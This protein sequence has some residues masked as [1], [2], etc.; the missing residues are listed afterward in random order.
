MTAVGLLLSGCAAAG[1]TAGAS[2]V[3]TASTPPAVTV[4]APTTVPRSTK[5]PTATKA[6]TKP[7]TKSATTTNA[8]SSAPLTLITEPDQGMASID[9][10][11]AS[12]R[13]T[14]DMTMYELVD[15]TAESILAADAARGVTVRVVL[16]R[17]REEAANTPAY[18]YLTS[19][20]VHVRWAPPSFEATHEK[21]VVIDAGRPGARALIMTLNLT[22]EY[23]SDTRDFAVIDTDPSDVAAIETVFAADYAGQPV[24]EPSGAD[25]VWSP[26][27]KATL[28]SLIDSA[29]T[30][31][32]VEN[33]EMSSTAIIDALTA[34]AGRGVNVEVT[35]TADSEWDQ[36]FAELT[37]AGA[38]VHLYAD[39]STVL[40]IHAKAIVADGRRAFVGSENFSDA[41]LDENRE[42]GILTQSPAIVSPLT[43]V[44]AAD[45][46]GAAQTTSPSAPV[47]V[48]ASP[49]PQSCHPLT[50]GGNCYR[51]GEYCRDD[52]HGATGVAGDGETIT[53]EEIG[54][55]WE[56]EAA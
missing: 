44:L 54:A 31:L 40:Y 14:L 38:H 9:S 34:A 51:Q 42:L 43:A 15:S 52:D 32:A 25:L 53:C 16:D 20:G 26:G 48:A 29:R 13:D 47:T 27:S 30:S 10:L 49:S 23:Y 46:A 36:A 50:D 55:I 4:V 5:L 28:V 2:R 35:M 7:A 33:E 19:H 12:P 21:A 8:G 56:W 18:D 17:N 24:A 41:S 11:L 6:T 39:T 45:Y 1:K 3:S 37:A 22:S